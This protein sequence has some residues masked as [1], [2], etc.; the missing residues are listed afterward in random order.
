MPTFRRMTLRNKAAGAA[1]GAIAGL[2]ALSSAASAAAAPAAPHLPKPG[3]NLLHNSDFALPKANINTGKAPTGWTVVDLG[4]E[5]KPFA[6]EIGAYNKKG[7]YPPPKGNPNKSDI[8]AQLFYEGGSATG[9]EGIGGQQ[10]K[11]VFKSV[12]QKNNPQVSFSDVESFPPS[13]V[14]VSWAGCGLE[15]V[16]SVGKK[17]DTVVFFNPFTPTS[18][19]YASK[20]SNSATLKY[21]V[22][23]TLKLD[24]WVT[25]KATSLSTAVKKEF[26]AKSYK[27]DDVRYVNLEGTTSSGK[28]YPNETSYFT[29]LV[30]AEGK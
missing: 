3:T 5:K 11:S 21:V 20:P 18:G 23:A 9:V 19:K 10:S 8:A 25:W 13:T 30:L 6:A 26:G 28:P 12:T 14:V 2:V 17:T 7:K 15:V 22:G 29:D 27:V 1:V 4:A 16:V 24:K